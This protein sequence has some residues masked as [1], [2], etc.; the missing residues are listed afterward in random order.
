MNTTAAADDFNS[1]GQDTPI[2]G[3]VSDN[4]DDPEG[5]NQLVDPQSIT[6]PEGTFTLLADGSYTFIPIE[7]FFGPID[8]PYNTCDDNI[9]Q[10]CTQATLHL[11]VVRD[12]YIQVRV[13]LQGSMI[14]NG[15]EIGTTSTRPLMRDGIRE[16]TFTGD[17]YIPDT[18]LLY[19]SPSPRDGLLS[20]MP[21]SA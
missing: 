10:A 6:V 12:M 18:C 21:S 3:N 4:D 7:T 9:D 13:Y 2:T 16:S 17:R 5:D 11:L 14:N 15:N 19:T 1:G 20:R 8:F